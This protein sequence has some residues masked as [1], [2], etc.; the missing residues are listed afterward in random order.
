MFSIFIKP[1]NPPEN[2]RCRARSPRK[3]PCGAKPGSAAARTTLPLH[4]RL[5]FSRCYN[6]RRYSLESP[7]TLPRL[8]RPGFRLRARFM[9]SVCC[10]RLRDPLIPCTCVTGKQP[11]TTY[12]SHVYLSY[13]S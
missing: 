9:S 6:A 4:R 2:G 7:S 10:R 12:V 5:V 8:S 3:L 1:H 13:F 11:M